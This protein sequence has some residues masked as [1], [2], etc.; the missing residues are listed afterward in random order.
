MP[1]SKETARR[2]I[3]A[4]VAADTAAGRRRKMPW[5][6]PGTTTRALKR[7][8]SNSE[9]L[10]SSPVTGQRA[11]G[12]SQPAPRRERVLDPVERRCQLRMMAEEHV[13]HRVPL[14]PA[15]SLRGVDVGVVVVGEE[16]IRPKP[17]RGHQDEDPERR[18]AE[19]EAG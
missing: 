16:A 17:P 10:G 15:E 4:L 8:F 6:A 19:A 3:P 7:A 9:A 11:P 2:S 5:S 14:N 18:V 12:S 1:R 13:A